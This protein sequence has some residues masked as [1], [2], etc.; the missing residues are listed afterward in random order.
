MKGHIQSRGEGRWRLK[1]DVGRDASTGKRVT[2]FITFHGTK[3]AAQNE[4]ARLVSQANAGD[5]I[6]PSKLTLREYL[7]N[8]MNNAEAVAISAKTAERYRQLIDRQIIPYL[9]AIVLQRLRAADVVSWHTKLLHEGRHDGD[10][11]SPRTVGHAHRVLRKALAD[12]CRGELLTRNPAA[13]VQ[14]PKVDTEEMQ[15]L[16]AEQVRGVLGGLK[17]TPIFAPVVLL[18][19]TG[20]RRGELMALRWGDI[21]LEAG[22]L[23]VERPWKR[24]RSTVSEK[25]RPR[26]VMVGSTISLPPIA[27]EALR[28]HRRKQ[29]EI[30]KSRLAWVS[31]QTS[32]PFSGPT[33]ASYAIPIGSP[34]IGSATPK[35]RGL[36]RVTLHALRHSHASALI[37]AG[38]DVLTISRRLG[39]GSPNVTLAVYG[40]VFR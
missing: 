18:L 35:S 8:W 37:A 24:R 26:R 16:S 25:R 13:L 1:F 31:C 20:M 15:I 34:R 28:G 6:E 36:P 12:A 19:S 7:R 14:P 39:H 38:Q 2:R 17:G 27:I 10:P 40:H 32:I 4:L 5:A 22:K 30:R 11:L 23:K 29:L 33:T 9:G 21:D 3:R